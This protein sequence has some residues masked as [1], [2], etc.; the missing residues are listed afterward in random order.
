VSLSHTVS[1]EEIRERGVGRT[2]I[3]RRGIIH[4]TNARPEAVLLVVRVR[5]LGHYLSA[6][7]EPF[8]ITRKS[9]EQS[10]SDTW[11][12]SLR[13]KAPM[14]PFTEVTWEAIVPP[15]AMEWEYRYE[16]KEGQ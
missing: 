10:T 1:S 3:E 9:V 12:W 7:R 2:A 6:T 11:D 5:F 4:V 8:R 13:Q 15:G 14:N 16:I